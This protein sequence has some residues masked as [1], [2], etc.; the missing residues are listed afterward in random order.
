[1]KQRFENSTLFFLLLV[2]LLELF[3]ISYYKYYT[4]V[5]PFKQ[6]NLAYTGNIINFIITIIAV[7]GIFIQRLIGLK[8]WSNYK[9]TYISTAIV[10]L[11]PYV[12]VFIFSYIKVDFLDTYLLGYPVKKIWIGVLLI[13]SKSYLLF[14]IGMLWLP[15]FYNTVV[16][17][18]SIVFSILIIVLL[19][20]VAFLHALNFNGSPKINTYNNVGIVFGAAVWSNNKPSPMFQDRIKQAEKLFKQE[21]ISL[22]QVTGGNAPGELSEAQSAYNMLVEMGVDSSRVIR[23]DQTSNTTEQIKYIYSHQEEYKKRKRQ[24]ILISDSFHLPRISEISKFFNI[25]AIP[26]SSEHKLRWEKLLYYRFRESV[27]LLLFWIF[28]I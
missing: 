3:L 10:I 17:L 25:S 23:E 22:I 7:L 8:I 11:L 28:G 1:M 24:I 12:F 21:R 2:V 6:F 13:V 15:L 26:S 18:R 4:N 19:L 27:A 5:L 9:Y 14:L 20:F 16:R